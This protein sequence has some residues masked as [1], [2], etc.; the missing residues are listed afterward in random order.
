LIENSKILKN[1]Y[2]NAHIPLSVLVSEKE[3][4]EKI[5]VL[6]KSK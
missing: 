6:K 4:L 1:K 5:V 3:F 2:P